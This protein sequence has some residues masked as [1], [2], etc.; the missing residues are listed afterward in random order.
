MVDRTKSGA[1]D[2]FDGI[3]E[4]VEK[5]PSQLNAGDMQWHIAMKPVDA[6][7]LAES[8][9][10]QFHE[11]IRISGST[12]DTSVAEGSVLDNYIKEVEV[13]LPQTKKA[14]TI[15]EVMEAMK[16]KKF[17]FV[18]KVLGKSYEGKESKPIFVPQVEL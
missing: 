3:V 9:T 15:Q 17:R 10:G 11:W 13:V 16:G 12:T 7:L 14:K 1:I 6:T 4:V 8:R 18:R 5:V 2:R